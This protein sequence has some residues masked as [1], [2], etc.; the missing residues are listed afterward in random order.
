MNNSSF[1]VRVGSFYFECIVQI[2]SSMCFGPTEGVRGLLDRQCKVCPV[3][4]KHV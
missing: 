4:G 1:F 3:F 2:P